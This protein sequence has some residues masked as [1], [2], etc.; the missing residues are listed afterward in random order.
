MLASKRK[1]RA[2]LRRPDFSTTRVDA[3]DNLTP[4]YDPMTVVA[5]AADPGAISYCLNP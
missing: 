1:P 4:A 2:R 3:G 5:V